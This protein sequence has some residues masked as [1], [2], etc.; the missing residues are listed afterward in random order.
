[1]SEQNLPYPYEPEFSFKKLMNER[2]ADLRY[3]WK[4]RLWLFA[5]LII[6]ALAGAFVVWYKKPTYT[7]R[8]TFVVD[9]AKSGGSLG[10]LSA[11]AGQ[12]GF[13][14]NGI[15]GAS[16]VL[17]GDNVE[18]LIKSTKLIKATLVTPYDS[19]HTLADRYAAVYK[20]DKQWLRYSPDG[21]II[22]F[23]PDGIHNTRLQDSLLHEMTERILEGG[24]FEIAKPDKKLSFFEVN[25]TMKDEKLAFLFCNRMITQSTKFFISTKTKHLRENVSRLQFRSDSIKNILNGRT[26]AVSSANKDVVDLNPAYTSATANVEIKDREKTILSTIYS[27]TIKNLEASKTILAQ[28]TPTIQIVDEPELPLKKNKLKYF[29]TIPTG[30]VLAGFLFA[31]IVLLTRGTKTDK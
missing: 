9:D 31:V 30:A 19:T 8:L 16:G 13:D 11:L 24:Q 3:I 18:A 7:A 12:L 1:M 29:V 22:Q 2:L 10:G 21:K 15:G 26:Y 23:P 14:L 6:G 4:F 28:E 17:A 27:E 5:A 20:L 25:T